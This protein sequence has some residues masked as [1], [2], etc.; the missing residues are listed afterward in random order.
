MF[1]SS[2]ASDRTVGRREFLNALKDFGVRAAEVSSPSARVALASQGGSGGHLAKR[3]I[4]P[5]RRERILRVY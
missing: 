2:F 1:V 5:G 3:M 4:P